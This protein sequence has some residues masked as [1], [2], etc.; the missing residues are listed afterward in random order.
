MSVVMM[1]DSAW[2]WIWPAKPER[3]ELGSRAPSPARLMHPLPADPRGMGRE[4][5]TFSSLYTGLGKLDGLPV[6]RQSNP[7]IIKGQK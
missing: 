2:G 6:R 1:G 4:N 3:G 5:G 7:E